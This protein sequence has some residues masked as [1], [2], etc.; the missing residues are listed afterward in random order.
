MG[1]NLKTPV[2]LR[3][4]DDELALL[5]R[6]SKR[7]GG[8]GAA[9]VAGLRCLEQRSEPDDDELLALL[10]TRLFKRGPT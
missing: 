3:M 4:T 5:E 9:L 10:R 2:S 8:K 7:H 6:L 1:K